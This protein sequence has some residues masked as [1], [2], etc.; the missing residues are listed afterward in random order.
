MESD[1]KRLNKDITF[2]TSNTSCP[3]CK[4]DIDESFRQNIL[5]DKQNEKINLDERLAQIDQLIKETSEV[6]LIIS[7]QIISS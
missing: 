3:S 1:L 2:Y 4:Q 5:E 6:L 7:Y